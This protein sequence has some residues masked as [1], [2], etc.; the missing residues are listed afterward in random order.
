VKAAASQAQRLCF[1]ACVVIVLKRIT[2]KA[3]MLY[4]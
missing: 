1:L 4:K 2:E 3:L